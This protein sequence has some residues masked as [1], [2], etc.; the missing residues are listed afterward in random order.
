MTNL[1]INLMLLI[2][3]FLL[4]FVGFSHSQNMP[5]RKPDISKMFQ[6]NGKE[7][8]RKIA[9]S[10]TNN[11]NVKSFSNN[12]YTELPEDTRIPGQFEETQAVAITWAYDF[13]IDSLG[14]YYVG[15]ISTYTSSVDGKISHQLAAAIQQ[16]A[17]V[18]IRINSWSDSTSVINSM[19][20]AGTPLVNYSFYQL[21]VDSWWDRDSGPISFYY[22]EQDSIGM[23]DMDYYTYA[24]FGDN[25][26]NV[27]TD[28][29]LINE[30]GRVHDDSIPIALAQK[31]DY[32]VYHTPLNDE[33]G[34]LIFDGLQ[35]AWTST[36]AR[37]FNVGYIYG[38]LFDADGNIIYNSE[39]TWWEEDTTFLIYGNYPEINDLEYE[40]LF[41]NSFKALNFIEPEVFKCDGGTGHLD[42]YSKLIDENN[43]AIVDY[44]QAIN[45]TDYQTWINNL[46]IFQSLQ[47]PNGKPLTFHILPMPLTAEGNVQVDCEI[48]QRTY[49]NGIFINKGFIMP[50]MSDPN[51]LSQAD[52]QA[53]IE[54]KKAMPGYEIH[55][56]DVTTMYGYGGALHCITMQIPAENPI[57]IRHKSLT[58][59]QD[60]VAGYALDALIKNK[61]GISSAFIYYKKTTDINWTELVLNNGTENNYSAIITSESF[62]ESDT[63]QY[64]IEATSNNGK[65][66]TKPFTAREGGS[67]N[68]VINTLTALG[69]VNKTTNFTLSAFPN[70]TNNF[71]TLPISLDRE[72]QVEINIMDI[73][74]RNIYKR[75]LNLKKGL[76]LEKLSK[77][78][79]I[80]EAGI[81]LITIKTDNTT[82][83]FQKIIIQ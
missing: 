47:D 8:K 14:N 48:D 68:F 81:Y 54:F 58:E 40:N 42:I 66:I 70:P 59:N 7:M 39:G 19:Q 45:H 26:G 34:N 75:K 31:F 36:G 67:Y 16:H 17:K 65:T 38:P 78:K 4:F 56:I 74:G 20:A 80:K 43:L 9:E 76:N 28:F 27:I 25:E 83:G 72:R 2:S 46:E 57:F 22:S 11:A 77:T 71:I 32:P 15:E 5:T 12:N 73:I 41:T 44:S 50:V 62:N 37:D 63:I 55:L 29:D 82:I 51:N 1:K 3:V 21:T 33:G 23:I 18:I 61:S 60:L 6:T 10:G 69:D 35:T 13:V 49:L 52:L 64:F 53:V 79:E 30:Q 24:A